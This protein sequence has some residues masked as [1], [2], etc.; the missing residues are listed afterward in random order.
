MVFFC[1]TDLTY[2]KKQILC[3]EEFLKHEKGYKL[4]SGK[5]F[6]L[7]NKFGVFATHFPTIFGACVFH[8]KII[9]IL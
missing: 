1:K 3:C 7:S 8:I 6:H 2:L 9:K 5:P 4:T